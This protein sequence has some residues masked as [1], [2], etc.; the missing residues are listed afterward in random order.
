[1]DPH[2]TLQDALASRRAELR[3]PVDLLVID[4]EMFDYTLL[5]TIRFDLIR[6]LAI[7]FETKAMSMQQGAEVSTLL[8]LH[9]Y[10]CRYGYGYG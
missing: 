1:M 2:I 7:E 3:V 6:P 5:R 10:L 4:V 9:G 8:A